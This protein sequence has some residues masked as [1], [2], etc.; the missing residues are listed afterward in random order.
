MVRD[1]RFYP[2]G[3]S[4]GI[5]IAD[6]PPPGAPEQGPRHMRNFID[7]VRSRK[8]DDLTAEILEGHRSVLLCH[9]GNIAYRLGEDVPFN[10]QTKTFDGDKTFYEA[11]E[12]M[13]SHLAD[14]ARLDLSESSYRLGRVT[15]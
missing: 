15:V 4:E 11:F 2:K 13:K 14:A 10:R 5:P 12:D 1:G 3:K 6:F 8:R 7:C 9:L